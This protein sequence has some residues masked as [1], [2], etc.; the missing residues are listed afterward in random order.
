MASGDS[1][2]GICNLGLVNGLGQDPISALSDNRKAAIHL[3]LCYDQVRRAVLRAHTWGFATKRAQLSAMATAPAFGFGNAFTLPSDFL[4]LVPAPGEDSNQEKWKIEGRA[5][6]SD[7]GAPL[8]I[9]YIFDCQ[10]PT[11]FDPLFV[12]ALAYALAAEVAIPITQ[13]K[14]LRAQM[15]SASEAR[16]AA[17][18]TV[19]SQDSGAAEWDNDVLL[20]SRL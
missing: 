1:I 18:K 14:Q 2:I 3:N 12:E 17:A 5:L 9:V 19:S 6:L 7:D 20:R 11:L 4:R 10:D 16:I 15:E 8:N 13:D